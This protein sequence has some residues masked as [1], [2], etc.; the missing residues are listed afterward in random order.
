M[1]YSDKA[2]GIPNWVEEVPWDGSYTWR[3]GGVKQ[4]LPNGDECAVVID[5]GISDPAAAGWATH[6]YDDTHLN[7]WSR[8]VDGLYTFDDGTPCSIAY[9]CNH[10]PVPQPTNPPPAPSPPAP[11]PDRPTINRSNWVISNTGFHTR[12]LLAVGSVRFSAPRV[13]SRV[14]RRRYTTLSPRRRLILRV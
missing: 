3:K 11:H 5:D 12:M 10:A 14:P 13:G 8:H 4:K 6:T 1:Y 7:C 9:I 2:W